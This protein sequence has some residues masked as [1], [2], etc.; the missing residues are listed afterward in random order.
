MFKHDSWATKRH[1]KRATKNHC[2]LVGPSLRVANITAF[3]VVPNGYCA[4]TNFD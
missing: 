1:W 2:R 4:E 3:T